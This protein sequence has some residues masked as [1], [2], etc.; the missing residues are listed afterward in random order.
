MTLFAI[1][2][3]RG[4]AIIDRLAVWEHQTL[5]AEKFAILDDTLFLMAGAVE[6]L[7]PAAL[8]LIQ[9]GSAEFESPR[10]VGLS[11]AVAVP[12]RSG[13]LPP[14]HFETA[15]GEPLSLPYLHF[16]LSAVSKNQSGPIRYRWSP[17]SHSVAYGGSWSDSFVRSM[18]VSCG[19]DPLEWRATRACDFCALL[20]LGYD[21]FTL[22]RPRGRWHL[23]D[24]SR[25]LESLYGD[26]PSNPSSID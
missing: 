20:G 25:A 22:D 11:S 24:H 23:S 14:F 15:G 16:Q 12:V 10:A 7:V 19:R 3:H 17:A 5:D 1:N 4:W 2:E 6:E 8:Q 26:G 21:L 13:S 9:H 18:I